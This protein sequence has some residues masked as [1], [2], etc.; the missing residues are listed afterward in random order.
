[1]Y[2]S[3]VPYS[4]TSRWQGRTCFI[5]RLSGATGQ[6]IWVQNFSGNSERQTALAATADGGATIAGEIYTVASFGA[7]TLQAS[8]NRDLFVAHCNANGQW[9]SAVAAPCNGTI[10][11]TAAIAPNGDLVV[12]GF[13]LGTVTC[14]ALPPLVGDSAPSMFANTLFTARFSVQTGQW[15]W[16]RQA[17]ATSSGRGRLSDL[18][19][20]SNG[21]VVMTGD[22]MGTIVLGSLPSITSPNSANIFVIRADGATGQWQWA[23]RATHASTGQALALAITHAGNVVITSQVGGPITFG[24]LPSL[25]GGGGTLAVASLAGGTGQWQWATQTGGN[26][27]YTFPGALA[28]AANDDLLLTGFVYD[29]LRLGSLAPQLTNGQACFVARLGAQGGPWR[30]AL[31]AAPTQRVVSSLP[32]RSL[33]CTLSLTATDEPLVGGLLCGSVGFGSTAILSGGVLPY[34]E[35][36]D[37]FIAKLAAIPLATFPPTLSAQ[38]QLYPNPATSRFTLRLPIATTTPTMATLF[39]SLGQAVRQQN[40][41]ARNQELI[42]D[43]QGLAPGLYTVRL[44][45]GTETVSRRLTVK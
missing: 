5:G 39:N 24:A 23:A 32:W 26:D 18:A 1:M 20:A 11:H 25:T 41:P 44:P 34:N 3:S 29:T 31:Q 15:Q 36:H 27:I 37:I 42:M 19:F 16:A 40:L 10:N 45:V 33:G 14:G 12:A 28:V 8:G 21:D 38:S 17:D 13:F 43:V 6:W 2:N 30:W 7:I 4:T 22:I 9:Q 35:G